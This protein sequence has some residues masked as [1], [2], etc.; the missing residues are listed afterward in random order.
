MNGGAREIVSAATLDGLCCELWIDRARVLACLRSQGAL[1]LATVN[2]G[3]PGL[4]PVICE[5]W[6]VTDGRSVL[7]GFDPHR[8]VE[9]WAGVAGS[10][11]GLGADTARAL[12]RLFSLGP[13]REFLLTVPNVLIEPGG[14]RHALVLG[15]ITD[16]PIALSI[17]RSFGYGYRKRLGRFQFEDRRRFEVLVEREVAVSGEIVD[18][19]PPDRVEPDRAWV[20]DYWAQPMLGRLGA[21]DF[22]RSWL[23]R[24]LSAAAARASRVSATVVLSP[25]LGLGVDEIHGRAVAFS[26]VASR[27][28]LP[29]RLAGA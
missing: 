28:S 6:Q 24:R 27:I 8:L 23:E 9:Q 16:N 7:A 25:A 2:H 15:M 5:L 4:S 19:A 12:S 17:D 22:R 29:C 18:E 13:Y 3:D 1:Q 11:F 21:R 10:W 20:D 26:N 14:E